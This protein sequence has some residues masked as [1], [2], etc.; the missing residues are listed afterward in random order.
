[1]RRPEDGAKVQTFRRLL[2]VLESVFGDL[3]AELQALPS[4]IDPHSAPAAW[5]PLLLRWLGLPPASE[6]PVERQREL[7]LLAP[8]LLRERG[9]TGA[10]ERLARLLAGPKVSIID[11]GSGPPP[12]ALSS[13]SGEALGARL[14]CDTLVLSQPPSGF[15]LGSQARVGASALGE[16]PL[17]AAE[18]YARRSR[19]VSIRV[20]CNERE[21]QRIEPLLRRYLPYFVPAH[22]RYA[23]YFVSAGDLHASPRLDDTLLLEPDLPLRLGVDARLGEVALPIA[24]RGVIL[25][26]ARFSSSGLLLI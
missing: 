26:Q 2:A 24:E 20:A 21:R 11:T 7:S 1:V 17:D 10:L 23:L 15:R 6:L 3:D 8:E 16:E 18:L 5:L 4:N 14:G 22:C 19:F 13:G 12:W 25:G 9:T